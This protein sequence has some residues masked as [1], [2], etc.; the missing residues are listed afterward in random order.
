MAQGLIE[1]K[2]EIMMG[3]PVIAG[4]IRPDIAEPEIQ[5]DK[6]SRL[7]LANAEYALIGVPAELLL[8]RCAHVVARATQQAG[9]LAGNVLVELEAQ[10]H[11]ARLGRNGNDAL[12]REVR[13]VSERGQNVLGF[14]RRIVR[15]YPFGG[16]AGG[17]IIQDDGNRHTRTAKTHGSMHDLRFGGDVWLPV[18]DRNATTGLRAPSA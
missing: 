3:K 8:Q 5:R 13:G 15:K 10:R 7:V 14:Q 2:P 11:A 18:H 4:R 9:S 1:I 6:H 16:L 12:A 17:K